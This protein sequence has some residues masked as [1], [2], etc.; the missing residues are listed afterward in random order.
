MFEY[1][2]QLPTYIFEEMLLQKAYLKVLIAR[3]RKKILLFFIFERTYISKSKNF[4]YWNDD[5]KKSVWIEIMIG[6]ILFCTEMLFFIEIITKIKLLYRQVL[7]IPQVQCRGK[8]SQKW[9][10]SE[11]CRLKTILNIENT[12]NLKLLPINL[13][14]NEVYQLKTIVNILNIAKSFK[15]ELKINISNVKFSFNRKLLT[16]K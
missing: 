15:F 13:N 7:V 6:K 4:L 3:I 2:F 9:S 10:S 16:V 8:E 12:F 5:L 1:L 11:V 14:E